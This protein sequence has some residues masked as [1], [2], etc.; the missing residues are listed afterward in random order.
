MLRSYSLITRLNRINFDFFSLCQMARQADWAKKQNTHSD[1]AD[2]LAKPRLAATFPLCFHNIFLLCCHF[3]YWEFGFCFRF[4]RHWNWNLSNNAGGYEWCVYLSC[5]NPFYD[6]FVKQN[7]KRISA[8]TWMELIPFANGGVV[9]FVISFVYLLEIGRLS[10][11]ALGGY[12]LRL[13]LR[14]PAMHDFTHAHIII[15]KSNTFDSH[16]IHAK[17]WNH[18]N[19][20]TRSEKTTSFIT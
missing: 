8:A 6:L 11:L 2:L 18:R 15:I 17:E 19:H 9:S 20:Y 12:I 1:K 3:P 4:S 16:R 13:R 5:F 10:K 7:H 14:L